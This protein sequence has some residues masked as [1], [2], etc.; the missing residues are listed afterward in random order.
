VTEGP[1]VME[2]D[3][4]VSAPFMENTLI[5]S[6]SGSKECV[7][8]DPGLEPQKIVALVERKQ[9][10]PVMLLMTHGH[11]DHIGGNKYLRERWPDIP[12]VIGA[13]DANMLTDPAANLSL[14]FGLPVT[15]PP[16][17]R[18]VSEGETLSVAG[19]DFD[20]L[21]V[22]GHSPGHVVYVS[23]Q[24]TPF[25]VLGG[26]VLFAGSIGRTDFPGG[27]PRQLVTGIRSKLFKLPDDTLVFPGHGPSTTT[28]EERRTNPYCGD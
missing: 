19:L 26:D 1:L 16:A 17:D 23:R 6:R 20:V 22:P 10:Q 14:M 3:I 9:L 12:I 18:V 8:V 27:N 5:V 4:V 28:G 7:I 13:G 11:A 21:E 24:T 2:I 25:T 15:S